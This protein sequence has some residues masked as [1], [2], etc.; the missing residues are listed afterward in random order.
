MKTLRGKRERRDEE[1]MQKKN[2]RLRT[3][4]T[5][6]KYIHCGGEEFSVRK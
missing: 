3:K 6:G 4:W 2:L 1:T 5:L